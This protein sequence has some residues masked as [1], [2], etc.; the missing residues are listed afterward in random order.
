M[1]TAIIGASIGR[2]DSGRYVKGE[3][4]P[5]YD[6][7]LYDKITSDDASQ[8]A[9]NGAMSQCKMFSQV[10][11]FLFS[12]QMKAFLYATQVSESCKIKQWVC[13]VFR[14]SN[15]CHRTNKL[16]SNV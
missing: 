14:H 9:M 15:N 10:R 12:V 7:P 8:L 11:L 5:K 3:F 6:K 2:T 4:D 1:E 16:Q 13:S